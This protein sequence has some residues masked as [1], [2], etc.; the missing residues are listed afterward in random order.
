MP[1]VTISFDEDLLAKGRLYARKHKMSLNALLRKLLKAT[2]EPE[3]PD[4]LEQCFLLMDQANGDSR[5]E[6]WH[7][8]ELYGR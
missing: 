4:W 8:E 5:G 7:R 1:N 3:S 6:K 2:V